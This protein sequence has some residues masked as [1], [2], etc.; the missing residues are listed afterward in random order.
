MSAVSIDRTGE[1]NLVALFQEKLARL[2]AREERA[3]EQVEIERVNTSLESTRDCLPSMTEAERREWLVL[4]TDAVARAL[5]KRLP[6]V[7]SDGLER[8]ALPEEGAPYRSANTPL[9]TYR[10]V[11]NGH[12]LE[13]VCPVCRERVRSGGYGEEQSPHMM[14]THRWQLRL[15]MTGSDGQP[16]KRRRP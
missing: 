9:V 10:S 12:A 3:Q 15:R 13:C 2:T 1:R 5:L 14:R 11:G 8:T 4:A 7:E 16:Y 6:P